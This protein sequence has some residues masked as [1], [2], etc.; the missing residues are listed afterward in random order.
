V[1][2]RGRGGTPDDAYGWMVESILPA[3][4]RACAARDPRLL[5]AATLTL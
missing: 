3:L 4:G 1:Q 2:E 5:P